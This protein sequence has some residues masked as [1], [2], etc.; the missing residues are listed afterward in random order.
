MV[1]SSFFGGETNHLN[2]L[3]P[4]ED[5]QLNVHVLRLLLFSRREQEVL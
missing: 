1:I 4:N 3:P 2:I 5:F